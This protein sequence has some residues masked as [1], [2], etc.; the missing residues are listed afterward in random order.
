M[1]CAV[2]MIFCS[3]Q[4]IYCWVIREARCSAADTGL[5]EPGAHPDSDQALSLS[6]LDTRM[7]ATV[8][9]LTSKVRR[10]VPGEQ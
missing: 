7:V 3:L 4:I 6:V 1:G 8:H 2:E 10:Y 9:I 5:R